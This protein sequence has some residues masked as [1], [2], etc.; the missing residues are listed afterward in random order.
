MEL[1]TLVSDIYSMLE[2]LNNNESIM[3]DLYPYMA[4]FLSEMEDAVTHWAIPQERKGL[5]MSN[6]GKPDRQL[7]YDMN[8]DVEAYEHP[9]IQMKFLLGHVLEQV[10]LL[11]IRASG[12]EVT[13][14]QDEVE[15]D[16]ILGHMDSVIDGEVV[17]IKSASPYG[18][19]K[20]VTGDIVDND[21][22]GY[23]AQ[24]A[25]YEADNGTENGGNLVINK[26]TGE[27]T[28]FIP[29]HLDKPNIN[30]RIEHIKNVIAVDTPPELCYPTVPEGKSGNRVINK[31]CSFCPHKE[32]CH[33]DSNDG[34]GLRKFKY[35]NGI[36]YFTEVLKEPRVEEIK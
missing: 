28:L 21:P 35:S 23:M 3:D 22:F 18:F 24:I 9:S 15:V 7:W 27:L 13:R 6:I 20:F 29:T 17:D 36:K 32:E 19:N 26:V 4:L 14:T 16:G 33:A 2:R 25:G 1:K 12:H 34:M 5:R 31:Q 8:R 30:H 10:L 11:L